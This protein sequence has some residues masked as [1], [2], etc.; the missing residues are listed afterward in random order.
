VDDDVLIPIVVFAIIL[1]AIFVVVGVITSF[2]LF[3]SWL[4]HTH[5]LILAAII[6]VSVIVLFL[7]IAAIANS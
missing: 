6:V 2:V 7:I 3:T 1:F 4:Y 5:P